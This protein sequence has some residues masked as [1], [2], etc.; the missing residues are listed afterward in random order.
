VIDVRSMRLVRF[1]AVPGAVRDQRAHARARASARTGR[2][3]DS[4]SARTRNDRPQPSSSRQGARRPRQAS[5]CACSE[6]TRVGGALRAAKSAAC[7]SPR[8]P[9]LSPFGDGHRLGARRWRVS[10]ELAARGPEPRVMPGRDPK[11]HWT[12]VSRP[13]PRPSRFRA[14]PGQRCTQDRCGRRPRA[15]CCPILAGRISRSS[16]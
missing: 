5:Q 10:H 6:A 16:W 7:R 8:R 2:S 11:R 3:L 15:P 13:V 9:S 12:R 4:R 1:G 14:Q